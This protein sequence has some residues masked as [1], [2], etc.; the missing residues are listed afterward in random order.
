MFVLFDLIGFGNRLRLLNVNASLWV[1]VPVGADYILLPL[2]LLKHVTIASG[3]VLPKIHPEL[4]GRK[5]GGKFPN[6]LTTP[7]ILP[8]PPAPAKKATAKVAMAPKKAL[9]KKSTAAAAGKGGKGKGVGSPKGKVSATVKFNDFILLGFYFFADTAKPG[10]KDF[11]A[12]MIG[13][14]SKIVNLKVSENSLN[15]IQKQ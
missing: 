15:F 10:K 8:P 11:N 6:L 14:Q 12:G 13:I 9:L 4:L 1:F 3:G 2:Q 7:V 5:K